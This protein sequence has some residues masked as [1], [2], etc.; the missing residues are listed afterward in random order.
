MGGRTSKRE[1]TEYS[2]SEMEGAGDSNSGIAK[3]YHEFTKRVES[4]SY[5]FDLDSLEAKL[6]AGMTFN[7]WK[8]TVAVEE[9][10]KINRLA[11]FARKEAMRMVLDIEKSTHGHKLV[12]DT[13]YPISFYVLLSYIMQFSTYKFGYENAFRI[14]FDVP[15]TEGYSRKTEM[16]VKC[17][18]RGTIV[19]P[20][21]QWLA[22]LVDS[23]DDRSDYLGAKLPLYMNEVYGAK[24][25]YRNLYEDIYEER[26]AANLSNGLSYTWDP[27]SAR[28]SWK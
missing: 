25:G 12:V 9:P 8:Q 16:I 2:V 11:L 10:E 27:T 3:A 6:N 23:V 17:F 22:S 13:S 4:H 14:E 21:F 1:K 7:T 28:P 26:R 18:P 5:Q 20:H 19:R 15:V 24:Y